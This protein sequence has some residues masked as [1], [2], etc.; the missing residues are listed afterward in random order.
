MIFLK[1]KNNNNLK[2][3]IIEYSVI[4]VC[5]LFSIARILIITS[6]PEIMR[7]PDLWEI[8]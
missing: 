8:V 1:I 2:C 5:F 4:T 6:D 7:D 3:L